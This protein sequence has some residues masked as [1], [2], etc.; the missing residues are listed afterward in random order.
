MTNSYLL[1]TPS[2]VDRFIDC[3]LPYSPLP[4][5]PPFGHRQEES[6][7]ISN[8]YSE[9]LSQSPSHVILIPKTRE[10]ARDSH[11]PGKS[12][13]KF[14]DFEISKWIGYRRKKIYLPYVLI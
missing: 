14:T 12:I 2:T 3:R 7:R 13:G 5:F 1:Q 8:T 9:P 4:P 6:N 11:P 10:W